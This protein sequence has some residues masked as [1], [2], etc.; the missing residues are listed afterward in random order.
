MYNV[1]NRGCLSINAVWVVFTLSM[2]VIL[3]GCLAHNPPAE[4]L[5]TSGAAVE[6]LSSNVS[7][8]YSAP[9]R[10]ASGS[11]YLMFRKPDQMRMVVLSP[12][13]SVLQEVYVSG[14][15]ITI[16]D[17]GNGLAFTGTYRDLP[18]TGDFS[19]W[20]YLRWLID[21]DP[22][23]SLRDTTVIERMNRFG[24]LEKATF[25]KGLLISKSTA[26]AGVVRY[27]KYSAEH[28]VTF[29]LE[30]TYKNVAQER[31]TISLEE[32]EINVPFVEGSFVPNLSKFRVYPLSSLK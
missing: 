29:P 14:E 32:P 9:D 10:S 21:I 4:V 11:G 25:E 24:E 28:G 8:S 15:V 7:L 1:R 12:F 16:I 18:D 13:G 27:G 3:S 2:V 6:S 5:Y 22:P 31:F 20:R 30:I 26:S 17:V 23:D 19:N